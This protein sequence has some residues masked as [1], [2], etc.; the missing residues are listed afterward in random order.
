MNTYIPEGYKSLLGVYDT[1]KAIGLLKRLFE[2]QLAANLNLFR[3]SAPL[4]LEES[5]GLNDNLNGYE[6]P[7]SFDILQTGKE[8]QVVQSLAKW[9]RMALYRYDFYPGKGLYTDMNA[10]RRDEDVLDNLHS[11]YVDQWDWEKVITREQRC[12]ETLKDTVR[13]IMKALCKTQETLANQFSCLERYLPEQISF[14]TSQ[15][16]EDEYPTLS[17]KERE[18]AAAKKYGAVFIMQIGGA[19]KSGKPHDGRA[20]DYDDWS[21]NGDIIIWYPVLGRAL[22]LSSMGIRVDADALRR[23]FADRH[24]VL[25]AG[26]GL[27]ESAAD[28]CKALLGRNAP[29]AGAVLDADALNALAAGKYRGDLPANTILTPHPGEAAR[30][31]G[32]TVPEVQADREGAAVSLAEKYHCVAVLKGHHT[33]VAAPD[34]TVWRNETGNAGLAKG[35]SGD[36]LAGLT[37][38]LLAACLKQGRTPEDAAVCAVWLHGAAADRCAKRRSMT[39]MLP[40]DLFQDLGWI[41]GELG[42]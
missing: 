35:G 41:L 19:L 10:I 18:D 7:V 27:G 11:V 40:G 8:A 38:G 39:A 26:P 32:L 29:W 20:P 13:Q 34:G 22:E 4:F 30:L 1:Q 36:I 42:R 28:V 24:A 37:A 14:V 9:K 15:Q 25:L 3:V 12:A 33:L 17:P 23:W 31:L 2:D 6:R 21:L 16:L 5:S